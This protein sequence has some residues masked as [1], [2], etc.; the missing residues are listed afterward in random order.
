MLTAV[1]DNSTMFPDA[2]INNVSTRS[3]FSMT[4]TANCENNHNINKLI[5]CTIFFYKYDSAQALIQF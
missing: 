2:T 1:L 4:S 3:I 5:M